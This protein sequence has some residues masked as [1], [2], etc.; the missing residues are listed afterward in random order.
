M[1]AIEEVIQWRRAELSTAHRPLPSFAGSRRSL[2]TS[3]VDASAPS[4]RFLD[5]GAAP[6]V[7]TRAGVK[8]DKR[9][10]R[11]GATPSEPS[12]SERGRGGSSDRTRELA[13]LRERPER[14]RNDASGV[15]T[16]GSNETT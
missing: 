6:R 4:S 1:V 14:E 5:A 10:A 16:E 2:V 11:D 8:S 9:V 12:F 13:L 7:A 15:C 3:L